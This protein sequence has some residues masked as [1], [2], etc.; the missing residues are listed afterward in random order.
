MTPGEKERYSRQ[1]LFAPIG[2]AGQKKLRGACICIVGCGALGSFQAEALVRAGVGQL[3]LID[4]DYVDFTNLQRQWLFDEA[5]ARDEVPKAI[6][7]ARRLR[8]LNSGVQIEP[9]VTDVTPSN[10]E[11]LMIGCDLILDGT[12]NFETR[13]L[14]NDISVKQDVP[15][16]YGAAIGSYGIVMPISP[17]QGPCFACV[18]PEPPA[19]AQPTCDVNG[20]L[21]SATASVAALQV[22]LA[23]RL[24]VGWPDFT[25]RIQTLDV[26]EGTAK[27]FSTGPRDPECRV[28]VGRE[29][30][31]LEGHRQKPVSLCGRNAVQLHESARPLDLQ[32]LATRLRPLGDVRVNEFALRIELPKYHMTFFPDGRAI[33]KGTTDIG[34]AKSLYARLVG[35]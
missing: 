24:L 30:L 18:Y 28:C 35:A 4:R 7:A 21:A 3:R 23:L 8:H 10:I 1:I 6:A 27:Q 33:I 2:E 19:G 16:I 26:W 9:L 25:C 15:W 13:Y 5:D 31:Y 20:V 34:V 12:D 32:Q 11:E 14:L 29:F 22:A 17:K